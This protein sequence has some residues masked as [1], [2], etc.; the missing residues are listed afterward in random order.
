MKFPK[1]TIDRLITTLAAV[2]APV[3]TFTVDQAWLT[4][5]Q[6][7]DLGGILAAAVG[8]YHGGAAVQRRRSSPSVPDLHV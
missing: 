1:A 4:A 5:T 3:L 7:T 2:S 8:S 6:A